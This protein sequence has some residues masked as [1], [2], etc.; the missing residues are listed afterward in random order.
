MKRESNI[1]DNEERKCNFIGLWN[2]NK[3]DEVFK[4]K[5]RESV[6]FIFIQTFLSNNLVSN[7]IKNDFEDLFYNNSFEIK[8][9]ISNK[10]V[11]NIKFK[12]ISTRLIPKDF[13]KLLEY[14]LINDDYRQYRNMK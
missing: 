7:S 4:N 3:F 1:C 14:S 2:I 11:I 9:L 6:L 12:E 10:S 13:L 5:Y 8:P